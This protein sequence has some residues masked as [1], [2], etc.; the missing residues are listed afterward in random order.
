MWRS[1]RV[2]SEYTERNYFVMLGPNNWSFF[3]ALR[4]TFFWSSIPFKAVM[5]MIQF[6]TFKIIWAHSP[7]TQNESVSILRIRRMN[8]FVYWEYAERIC[9]YSENMRNEVN[10][11]T[12]FCCSYTENTWN[13]SVCILR[14]RWMNLFVYWEYSEWICSILRICGMHEKSN[15]SANSKQKS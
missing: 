7:N 13:V 12:K 11:R 1:F 8:L 3:V 14:I 4:P 5:K 9:T 2:L 6:R 10:I 15:I